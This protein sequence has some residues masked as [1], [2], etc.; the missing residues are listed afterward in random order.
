M[1]KTIHKPKAAKK[2]KRQDKKP[3]A[4]PTPTSKSDDSWMDEWEAKLAA[5]QNEYYRTHQKS[6]YVLPDGRMLPVPESL[7]ASEQDTLSMYD[8]LYNFCHNSVEPEPTTFHD[9]SHPLN[10]LLY[11]YAYRC[12]SLWEMRKILQIP[13]QARLLHEHLYKLKLLRLYPYRQFIVEFV[14][15]LRFILRLRGYVVPSSQKTRR[16]CY[17]WHPNIPIAKDQPY[18][19]DKLAVSY[20]QGLL[21][22]T[23][24][25]K[26]WRKLIRAV[27]AAKWAYCKYQ[28]WFLTFDHKNEFDPVGTESAIS[29]WKPESEDA[30]HGKPHDSGLKPSIRAF[31]EKW[32][33]THL[34][35]PFSTDRIAPFTIRAERVVVLP[36]REGDTSIPLID[37]PFGFEVRLPRYY[38]FSDISRYRKDDFAQLKDAFELVTKQR[39]GISGIPVDQAKV[40][41]KS[42]KKLMHRNGLPKDQIYRTLKMLCCLSGPISDSTMRKRGF[43]AP[44]M[45]RKYLIQD[46]DVRPMKLDESFVLLMTATAGCSNDQRGWQFVFSE[47][48]IDVDALRYGSKI[49]HPE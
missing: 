42:L 16:Y 45:E 40:L 11:M 27:P 4:T 7:L 21:K 43:V 22:N 14:D 1:K 15:L 6:D 25:M 38:G 31:C 49:N 46:K 41:L 5:A 48:G 13:L 30:G 8:S 34:G 17:C 9:H 26:E 35:T 23:E 18:P 32:A 3:E 10:C 20:E 24:F 33:L 37:P 2:S 47:F 12:I 39:K 19:K 29:G 28:D 44:R 36:K